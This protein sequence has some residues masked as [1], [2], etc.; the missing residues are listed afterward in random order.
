M[1]AGTCVLVVDTNTVVRAVADWS[2]AAGRVLKAAEN[3]R[4]RLLLSRPV[5]AEYRRVLSHVELQ[6]KFSGITPVT[7][8]ATLKA[9]KYRAGSFEKGNVRFLLSRDPDDAK[10]LEPA[11]AG[12]ATHLLT[13]DKDLLSLREWHDDAARRFRQR[14]PQTRIMT[15]EQFLAERRALPG[16]W[17]VWS[18]LE[19]E[20]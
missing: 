18:R 8:N 7:I 4:V 16:S 11:I 10:F 20:R 5:M 13:Y 14:A 9:M 17:Q 19:G 3:H 1:T 15:S 12:E 6:R 2:S